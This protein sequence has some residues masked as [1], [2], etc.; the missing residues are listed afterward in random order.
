MADRSC[1]CWLA[2]LRLSRCRVAETQRLVA[3]E[4]ASTSSCA[5]L[6]TSKTT[7]SA[8]RFQLD[9]R[10]RHTTTQTSDRDGVPAAPE[11][12]ARFSNRPS[13]DTDVFEPRLR[14]TL[15]RKKAIAHDST[16]GG[17]PWRRRFAALHSWRY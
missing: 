15:G 3:I 6:R 13:R 4:T 8:S 12:R 2:R 16:L 17:W 10:S 1:R 14:L 11:G 9:R 5:K 7:L